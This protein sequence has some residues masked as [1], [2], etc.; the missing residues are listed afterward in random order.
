M[1]V[2][3]LKASIFLWIVQYRK[4]IGIG[5]LLLQNILSIL[6]LERGE[7][8]EKERER[9]INECVVASRAPPAGY[10]AF[11]QGTCPDW[12]LNLWFAG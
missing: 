3:R 1:K 4:I 8:S 7:G 9:N 5:I 11:N 2:H 6:F 12:E 10:L